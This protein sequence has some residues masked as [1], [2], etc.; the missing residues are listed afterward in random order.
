M[1][2]GYHYL[3]F[4]YLETV[5]MWRKGNAFD[6]GKATGGWIISHF[7]DSENA[8]R[9]STD[10]E[11]KWGVHPS[12][13]T[14]AAWADDDARTTILL[15]VSGRFRLDLPDESIVLERQG[16][17]VMWG[18]GFRHSWHAEKDS[19]VITVRWPVVV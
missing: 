10:V 15:I 12:G 18:S 3:I 14:R 5:D 2:V 16:D 7:I 11:V 17:Y 1:A 19:V 4:R 6:D 9:R 8:L 13:D